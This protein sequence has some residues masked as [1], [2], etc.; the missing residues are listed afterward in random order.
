MCIVTLPRVTVPVTTE[1]TGLLIR[2]TKTVPRVWA[3]G[4]LLAS[5]KPLWL[6]DYFVSLI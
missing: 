2:K 6:P 1:E 5:L 4:G 3:G